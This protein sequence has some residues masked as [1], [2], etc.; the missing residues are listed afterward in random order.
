MK[1]TGNRI[2]KMKNICFVIYYNILLIYHIMSYQEKLYL[3]LFCYNIS[4]YYVCSPCNYY[5]DSIGNT[6]CQNCP[7]YMDKIGVLCTNCEANMNRCSKHNVNS[8]CDDFTEHLFCTFCRIC[9]A[10]SRQ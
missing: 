9:K 5:F 4:S 1:E 10:R 3:C 7:N 8:I 2:K 6:K